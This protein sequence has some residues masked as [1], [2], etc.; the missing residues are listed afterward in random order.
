MRTMDLPVD[1]LILDAGTQ[2]RVE[3]CNDTVDDYVAAITAT[4]NGDWPFPSLDVFHDGNQYMVADGFHRTISAIKANVEAVPC[5]VHDG[6]AED[7]RMFG[8]LANDKHGLRMTS[9]DKRACVMWLLKHRP[10]ASHFEMSAM[11]GVHK[12]TVE[13]I[14]SDAA[15]SAPSG[16]GEI[17]A[18]G[19][20]GRCPSCTATRWAVDPKTNNVTCARCHHSHGEHA[21]NVDES[22]I[23][24]QRQ[25]TSAAIETAMRHFDDLQIMH[26]RDDDHRK[27]IA[28]CQWMLGT[29][30][31]WR[32]QE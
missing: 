11:A 1:Q 12:R 27:S 25:K 24:K 16:V 20:H 8:M 22:W 10:D 18:E 6:S 19:D 32:E 17:T 7:A 30:K 28:L 21:E 29:V 31:R 26:A 23:T 14:A 15:L 2:N 9:T 5:H 3:I 4:D 13:R